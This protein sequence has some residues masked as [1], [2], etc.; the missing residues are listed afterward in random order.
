[1]PDRQRGHRRRR[2]PG[3]AARCAQLPDLLEGLRE[4]ASF[5]RSVQIPRARLARWE[6]LGNHLRVLENGTKTPAESCQA[7]LAFGDGRGKTTQTQPRHT[8]LHGQAIISKNEIELE[9]KRRLHPDRVA[10]GNRD[11]RHS[12][13]DAVAG[14]SQGEAKSA[15]DRLYEQSQAGRIDDVD[16]R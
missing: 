8:S 9:T 14:P 15:C 16:V 10:G 12:S 2:R 6:Q 1:M 4:D 5:L 3:S 7:G 11:Y 13:R